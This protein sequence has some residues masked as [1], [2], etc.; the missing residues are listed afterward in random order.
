ML[1]LICNRQ[2]PSLPSHLWILGRL[3]ESRDDR[4]EV[5]LERLYKYTLS[6]FCRK[7]D[8]RLQSQSS[9]HYLQSLEQVKEFTPQ[10]V[11]ETSTN[12]TTRD[13]QRESQEFDN[14]RRLPELLLIDAP[15]GGIP[16]HNMASDLKKGKPVELYTNATC[17]EFHQLLV[18]LLV[19]F[20]ETQEQPYH[21]KSSDFD[22]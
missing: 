2:E 13:S 18:K 6:V 14:D 17:M 5:Q 3:L 9:R 4:R 22:I 11:G 12:K 10:P 19:S 8:H 1:T 20:R 16:T 21:K 15:S 7:M